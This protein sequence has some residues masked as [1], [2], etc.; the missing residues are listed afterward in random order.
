MRVISNEAQLNLALREKDRGGGYLGEV[1]VSLG[2]ISERRSNRKSRRRNAYSSGRRIECGNPRRCFATGAVC[3]G[4]TPPLAA[5]RGRGRVLTVAM[6]DP[7]DI[8]AIDSIAQLTG[9]QLEITSAPDSDIADSLERHYAE[10]S[11]I[12]DTVEALMRDGAMP[13]DG[14]EGAES[15]MVRLADQIIAHAVKLRAT[16]IHI[17]PEERIVR[18]R[19]RVDG[20][21]RQ[22]ILI[23]SR[24]RSGL[25]ARIKLMAE[26]NVTEK[27]I[28]QDGRIRF[29][30]ERRDIDLRISTLPTNHGESIVMRVLESSDWRPN[31][32]ELGFSDAVESELRDV[33]E[34]PFGMVLVTGPTGSGKTTT[35][36]TALAEVDALRR[37]ISPWKIRSNRQYHWCGK[38][39]F[40]PTSARHLPL[41]CALCCAKTRA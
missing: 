22:E 31:F 40:A 7:F 32:F 33:I 30:H 36:Y 37:S 12:E 21:L 9:A 28:P 14:E 25:A 23:P 39:K 2:F 3:R 8:V 15:P 6:A 34:R 10:S 11:S 17:E 20:V 26:L 19:M 16:D 1:L 27:R 5:I 38:R 29:L 41:D 13:L 18:I 24:L 4:E 35:L